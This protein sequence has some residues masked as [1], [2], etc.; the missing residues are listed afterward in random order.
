MIFRFE[1][2]YNCNE[3]WFD[4]MQLFKEEFNQS[5]VYDANGNVTSVQ[6][7]ANQDNAFEYNGSND[8][9]KAT[10]AKGNKFNYTYDVKHKLTPDRNQRQRHEVYLYV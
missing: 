10:D 7:L 3:A 8:L 5:F 6:G 9:I 1:Y 4:G 2:N